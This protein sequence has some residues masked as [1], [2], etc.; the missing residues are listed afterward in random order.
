MALW[1]GGIGVSHYA[2][3]KGFTTLESTAAG[4]VVGSLQV[5]KDLAISGDLW[6]HL[7]RNFVEA[8]R[9]EVH[10]FMRIYKQTSSLLTVE[11]PRLRQLIPDIKIKWHALFGDDAHIREIGRGGRK[12]TM[13][14]STTK[15]RP[16]AC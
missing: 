16:T 10:V 7:A 6:D 8:A 9:G 15:T 4:R 13:P 5:C 12:P 1:S 14:R 3:R 11:I 2:E